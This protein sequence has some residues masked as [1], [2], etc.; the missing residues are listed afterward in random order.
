MERLRGQVVIAVSDEQDYSSTYLDIREWLY[1][2]REA[3]RLEEGFFDWDR[4][5]F[6][7]KLV[8]SQQIDLTYI[9]KLILEYDK[10]NK[11]KD[12]EQL[13]KEVNRILSSSSEH[14]T[15]DKLMEGFIRQLNPDSRTDLP[16]L[17]DDFLLYVQKCQ[18]E[19]VTALIAE[20]DLQ[21][22]AAKRYIRKSL[23]RGHASE[24]GTD[25]HKTLPKMSPINPNYLPKKR[26]VL[27]RIRAFVDKYKGIG[28]DL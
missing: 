19:E 27:E 28:G 22:E 8:D 7:V 25:L 23:I 24:N 15:K 3:K 14:R 17:L 18:H 1:R 11:D 26:R 21:E 10:K 20:E 13:I 5:T 2:V 16:V 6:E 4:I 12:E 9:L